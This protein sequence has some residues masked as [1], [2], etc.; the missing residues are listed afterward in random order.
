MAAQSAAAAP[1]TLGPEAYDSLAIEVELGDRSGSAVEERPAPV[2]P[3]PQVQEGA[4]PV[5]SMSG[6][7]STT[8]P[9]G[10]VAATGLASDECVYSPALVRLYVV[11]EDVVFI[12]PRFLDGVFRP[13]RVLVSL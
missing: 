9:L 7:S 10:S 4:L 1:V 11:G 13:P 12:P 2:S 8:T 3:L 5:G 6:S